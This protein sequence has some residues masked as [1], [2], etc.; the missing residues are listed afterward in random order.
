MGTGQA[1]APMPDIDDAKDQVLARY[2]K[3]IA[4]YWKGES[5]QQTI[6]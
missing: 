1:P 5:V 6:L 3:R 2:D 4:Y